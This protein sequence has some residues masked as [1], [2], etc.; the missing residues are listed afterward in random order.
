MRWIPLVVFLLQALLYTNYLTDDSYIYAQFARNL[1]HGELAF[2]RGE[3]VHAATSPL[4]A[5][6]GAVAER[7]GIPA[8]WF[9]KVLGLVCGAAAVICFTAA[10]R[11]ISHDRRIWLLGALAFAV[12]PWFVRW[13]SSGM[14]TALAAF[15]VAFLLWSLY[16]AP[17]TRSWPWLAIVV[18]TGPLVRPE[19]LL[20]LLLL[21]LAAAREPFLRRRPLFFLLLVLPSLAWIALAKATGLSLLPTTMF[22]KSTGAG[23]V[24]DRLFLNLAVLARIVAV[25]A[26]LPLLWWAWAF[27]RQ[28]R[29]GL[30]GWAS[31]ALWAWVVL[32]PAI[33]L[34]R[35]VQVVSRYLEIWLPIPLFAAFVAASGLAR[36]WSRLALLH[37]G[38]C[39]ALSAFWISPSTRAFSTSMDL[40]MGEFSDWLR[41]NTP[42]DCEVAAYDIGLLGYRSQRRIYD[43][44]GLV[45]ARIARLRR[46]ID[47]EEIVR[48]GRFLEFSQPDLLLHRADRTDALAGLRWGE[49][50]P[51]P[52]LSRRVANLGVSRAQPVVYT[53]YRLESARD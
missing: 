11:G 23:L 20:L 36:W 46:Q 48:S 38:V 6:C 34:W 50:T 5:A 45:D 12:Q 30:S 35:D 9:L 4:W 42:E 14:E 43:L 17:L 52:I 10:L 16:G 32:L 41:A 40:A 26:A 13:S 25:S 19:L 33:Y 29:Q 7:F 21:G 24:L 44:G 51:Q 37:L 15:C 22:A 49:L 3:I 18:G 8:F 28:R 1:A 53:L 27:L 39:V 2:N 31:A 47:D